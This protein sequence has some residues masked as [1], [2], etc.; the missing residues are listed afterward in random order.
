MKC[1]ADE[2]KHRL[3]ITFVDKDGEQHTFEVANGDNLLDIA[4]EH[5]L[6]MEGESPR[7]SRMRGA[8]E[9]IDVGQVLVVG[10][11]LAQ[12]AM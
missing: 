5:D 11:A 1:I 10:R 2:S 7:E 3:R 12:P 4:Q 9:L 8:L 6:E